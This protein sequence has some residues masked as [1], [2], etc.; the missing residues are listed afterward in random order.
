MKSYTKMIAVSILTAFVF[1][2]AAIARADDL[3]KIRAKIE[4]EHAALAAK[5]AAED[6]ERAAEEKKSNIL[7]AEIEKRKSAPGFGIKEYKLG[8]PRSDFDVLVE[9]SGLEC[10]TNR[11]AH[12]S[13]VICSSENPKISTSLAGADAHV[14][15]LAFENDKLSY[16]HWSVEKGD[17]GGVVKSLA[18]K[19]GAPTIGKPKVDSRNHTAE[20][21]DHLFKAHK[22]H[23]WE[24]NSLIL[25]NP[26]A[27]S[28]SSWAKEGG[29]IRAIVANI[30]FGAIGKSQYCADLYLYSKGF[31]DRLQARI[32]MEQ[33]NHEKVGI[34]KRADDL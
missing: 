22:I 7:A 34:K 15:M 2:S 8:T 12:S 13:F 18:E 21:V 31:P 30:D 33:A 4:E 27:M 20:Y 29:E 25:L 24:P 16:V 1:S 11:N 28:V 9:Q 32:D 6:E 5:Q 14:T 26:D 23:K 19:F 10:Q 17:N 3:E